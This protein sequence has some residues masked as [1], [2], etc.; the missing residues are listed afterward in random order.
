MDRFLGNAKMN[1]YSFPPQL[2]SD[3]QWSTAIKLALPDTDP[4]SEVSSSARRQ[5]NFAAWF[6][7]A[8]PKK[9]NPLISFEMYALAGEHF[10]Q[11]IRAFRTFLGMMGEVLHDEKLQKRVD[12]I[13][14]DPTFDDLMER[15]YRLCTVMRLVHK[16]NVDLLSDPED[17]E[18]KLSPRARPEL[19][20]AVE[21]TWEAWLE[22][23]GGKPTKK[24]DFL[25]FAYLCLECT[26]RVT[27]D[28]ILESFDRHVRVSP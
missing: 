8:Y 17:A 10:G 28:G 19:H 20:M 25:Q 14:N 23:T 13:Y 15:V 7:S 21:C 18:V 27:P 6:L 11:G 22:L 24:K 2:I 26:K 4:D 3:E 5:C 16:D 9:K 1:Q 12:L